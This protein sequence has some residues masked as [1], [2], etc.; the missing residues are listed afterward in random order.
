MEG[1]LTI[2]TELIGTLA[3]VETIAGELTPIGLIEGELTLPKVI[4]HEEYRGT[5]EVTPTDETQ[6]LMTA[7]MLVKQ[8]IV[9]N[10]I[11]SNYGLITWNG[12]AL[13]VS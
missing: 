9:I 2:E 10:P 4:E 3:P 7:D 1:Y 11:P 6:I 5:H 8:N 12:S 13:T